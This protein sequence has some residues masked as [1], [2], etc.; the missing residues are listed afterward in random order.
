MTQRSTYYYPFFLHEQIST[1]FVKYVQIPW[2][3]HWPTLY[4]IFTQPL[5]INFLLWLHSLKT[6]NM[7]HKKNTIPFHFI[8]NYILF[9]QYLLFYSILFP[10]FHVYSFLKLII[11]YIFLGDYN[12]GCLTFILIIVTIKYSKL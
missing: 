9:S 3:L 12:M 11:I 4:L 2:S 10:S 1:V 7:P 8:F 6:H 5:L